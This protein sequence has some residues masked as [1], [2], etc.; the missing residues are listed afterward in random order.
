MFINW[1][2]LISILYKLH[3]V[4]CDGDKK[5]HKNP[6]S[7]KFFLQAH[8]KR[9]KIFSQNDFF[10]KETCFQC[11][12]TEFMKTKWKEGNSHNI[13][14]GRSTLEFTLLWDHQTPKNPC[15]REK[16]FLTLTTTSATLV[17]WEKLIVFQGKASA[18]QTYNFNEFM[19]WLRNKYL[20][21][22]EQCWR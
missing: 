19:R 16:I 17:C 4:N 11:Q 22:S 7:I 13:P 8:K 12:E 1:S 5:I 10:L 21:K 14:T 20:E 9:I 15:S 6:N 2:I 3:Y 18:S